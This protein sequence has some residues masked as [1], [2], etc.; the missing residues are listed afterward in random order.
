MRKIKKINGYLVVKFNDREI[1]E[2]KGTGLGSFGVI[3]AEEYTGNLDLDRHVME[4]DSAETIEEAIEQARGLNSEFDMDEQLTIYTIIK[5]TDDSTVKETVDPQLMISK[6]ED[7]LSIQI[8]SRHYPE[9]NPMT[10]RHEL[11][12]FMMALCKLGIYDPDKCFVEPRHFETERRPMPRQFVNL[13]TSRKLSS[14]NHRTYQLGLELSEHCP[15]ND[16]RIYLN[17]FNMCRELDDQ[18]L[19]L[20]GTPRRVVETELRKLYFELENMYL[21]NY[22]IRHYRRYIDQDRKEEPPDKQ[23]A[24]Q[25]A[26]SMTSSETLERHLRQQKRQQKE[27][28]ILLNQLAKPYE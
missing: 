20:T 27:T 17:I 9:I 25:D 2:W 13:P 8:E 6:W 5:E 7:F 11:Y 21:M 16:C 3:D 26:D 22:A 28:R 14:Y 15:Q 18:A 23:T 10:A 4:Y 19:R 12:G 1:K 24:S